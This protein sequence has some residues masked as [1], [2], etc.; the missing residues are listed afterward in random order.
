MVKP[1]A[2]VDYFI[3]KQSAEERGFVLMK[4]TAARKPGQ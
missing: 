4:P 1:I 3:M 2:S